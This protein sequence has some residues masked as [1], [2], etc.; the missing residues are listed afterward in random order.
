MMAFMDSIE[1]FLGQCHVS[2]PSGPLLRLH[3]ALR[4]F[5]QWSSHLEVAPDKEFAS[6]DGRFD[7]EYGLIT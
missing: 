7:T 5:R 6:H 2:K 1:P 3:D 4:G